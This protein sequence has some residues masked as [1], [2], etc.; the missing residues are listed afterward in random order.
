[1]AKNTKNISDSGTKSQEITQTSLFPL[2]SSNGKE[3]GVNFTLKKTSNDG[4][5]LLL[6]EAEK[7]LGLIDSFAGC[8]ED[9]RNQFM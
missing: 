5:L 8:I 1:M 7:Q 2:T 6:R 9:P 3:V 4:G